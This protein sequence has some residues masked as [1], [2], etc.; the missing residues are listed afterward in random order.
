MDDG[1]PKMEPVG[2]TPSAFDAGMAHAIEESEVVEHPHPRAAEM[3]PDPKLLSELAGQ[4]GDLLKM[5]GVIVG[6]GGVAKSNHEK[7]HA[8]ED[9]LKE[10]DDR[11]LY[12]MEQIGRVKQLEDKIQQ[13]EQTI[14]KK[15]DDRI[16]E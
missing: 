9:R 13:L 11:Y 4:I 2:G 7:L 14:R 8:V 12:L 15:D 5:Q 16:S 6:L 10:I 1:I 3:L